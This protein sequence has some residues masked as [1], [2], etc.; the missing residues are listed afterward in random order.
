MYHCKVELFGNH[1]YAVAD[2][3]KAQSWVDK[4]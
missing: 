3:I 2:H 4:S 1:S